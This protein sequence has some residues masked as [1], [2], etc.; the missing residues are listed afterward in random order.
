MEKISDHISYKEAT[1]SNTA[2]RLGIDNTP[3]SYHLSNM[4]ILADRLFEP[5]RKWVGGSIKINSFFRCEELNRAIGGSSRSQHCEG[6]AVDIDDTF[7]NKSNAEMFAYIKNNLDFDQIIWEFGDDLNPD[8]VHMSY[9]S[10]SENRS[11][12]LRATREDGKTK[13]TVI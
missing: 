12:A 10:E 9:V 5:L 8:W 6:R 13:Y 3:N 7:G 1:K 2:S 4:S 11:R